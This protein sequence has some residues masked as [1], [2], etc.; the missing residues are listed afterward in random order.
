V[1]EATTLSSKVTRAAPLRPGALSLHGQEVQAEEDGSADV[2]TGR[3]GDARSVSTRKLCA[4]S[5]LAAEQTQAEAQTHRA[6]RLSCRHSSQPEYDDSQ[7]GAVGWRRRSRNGNR[8]LDDRQM[9]DEQARSQ[10]TPSPAQQN[11]KREARPLCD[12]LRSSS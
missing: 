9:P 5:A 4:T 11:G 2:R 7:I 8:R 6:G 10:Q 3:R 1:I 12:R